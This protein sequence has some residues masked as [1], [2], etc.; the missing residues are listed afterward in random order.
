MPKRNLEL[1]IDAGRVLQPLAEELVFV[2]GAATGL[3]ITDA[4]AADIRSTYDVDVIVEITS[5]SQYTAFGSRLRRL[6][7]QE[8]NSEGAPI[9]RWRYEKRIKLDVMPTDEKILGF[10]NR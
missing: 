4:A 7:F 1:L 9:C 2:G 10:S 8:D 5:I 3:L 6:G